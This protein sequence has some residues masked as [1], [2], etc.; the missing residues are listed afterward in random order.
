MIDELDELEDGEDDLKHSDRIELLED[1]VAT[2]KVLLADLVEYLRRTGVL[3]TD[4]ANFETWQSI[5]QTMRWEEEQEAKAQQA[6]RFLEERGYFIVQDENQVDAAKMQR[7]LTDG[8]K[9]DK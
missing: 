5:L 6:R 1:A 4:A 7:W 9:D 3:K 2:Q 8:S